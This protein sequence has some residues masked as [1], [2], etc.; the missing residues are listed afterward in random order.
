MNR[1]S[2]RAR[3]AV[4]FALAGAAAASIFA[5]APAFAQNIAVVNNKPIPKSRADAIIGQ[6]QQQGQAA[7]PELVKAVRDEL[8]NREILMQEADK[9][10]L[11]GRADIQAQ[12][13][14]SRQQVLIGA[15]AQEYFRTHPPTDA[16]LREGYNQ[17]SKNIG[18]A[19]EYDT[20]HILVDQEADAKA[21]IA[22]LKAGAS[23]D[24]LA[25]QSKDPSGANG[26][27]LGWAR[28]NA[29]VPEFSEAMVK[30]GKGRLSDAPV[31]S[32]YGFHV[33]RVDDI[34]DGRPPSFE[35]SKGQIANMIVQNQ[36]WQQARF[37]AMIDDLR[38]KAKVE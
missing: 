16:E 15:L 19:K 20:R 35:E 5:A 11:G 37:K 29:Y 14:R 2:L 26:G 32:Q 34:R 18:E 10:G 36:Q 24:E 12:I 28:A 6:L 7:T 23:F 3:H 13:E 22:K 30:L 1:T 33:I 8:I 9:K 17:V 38:S 4:R 27:K 21:I 31:R 25:K